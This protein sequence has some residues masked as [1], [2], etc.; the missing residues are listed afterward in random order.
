M[1]PPERAAGLWN[2]PAGDRTDQS[3]GVTGMSSHPPPDLALDVSRLMDTVREE[4]M[5]L[6]QEG[7]QKTASYCAS[8]CAERVVSA[9]RE[10]QRRWAEERRELERIYGLAPGSGFGTPSSSRLNTTPRMALA[11]T[12]RQASR[13]GS[14]NSWSTP[15]QEPLGLPATSPLN[16]G[17]P[18]QA[19]FPSSKVDEEDAGQQNLDSSFIDAY[20]AVQTLEE[21]NHQAA[22]A[23][24]LLDEALKAAETAGCGNHGN[25]GNH[26]HSGLNH[27]LQVSRVLQ[28]ASPERS[29]LACQWATESRH[30]TPG[31]SLT[32]PQG[33]TGALEAPPVPVQWLLSFQAKKQAISRP[34]SQHHVQLHQDLVVATTQQL[35]NY[36]S[37]VHSRSRR[38]SQVLLP[39]SKTDTGLDIS[40]NDCRF[41]Q[42]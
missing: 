15:C 39:M 7:V 8:I 33:T 18:L 30:P 29:K 34:R 35:E 14:C 37:P 12:S 5:Q 23:M 38:R 40:R 6:M 24:Q 28:S 31:A 13:P 10:M 4:I 26:V 41:P 3:R 2:D 19:A 20:D 36:G 25:H 21:R 11:P 27:G 42:L 1:P 22:R 9:R 32:A 17:A 16:E